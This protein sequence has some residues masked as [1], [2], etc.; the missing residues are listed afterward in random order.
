MSLSPVSGAE[1]TPALT[2][3]GENVRVCEPIRT[4]TLV[5]SQLLLEWPQELVKC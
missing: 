5:L 1:T 3:V 2:P 4:P